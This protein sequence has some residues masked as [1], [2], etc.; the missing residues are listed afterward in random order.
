MK[1]IGI[2]LTTSAAEEAV[3][4]YI[5]KPL[6]NKFAENIVIND[7]ILDLISRNEKE[8]V[9]CLVTKEVKK[10]KKNKI[11]NIIF[12]CSS[13][14]H[15]KNIAVE[16][17]VRIFAIDDFLI[18]ETE[19]IR[20]IAFLATAPSALEN[21]HNLFNSFQIIENHLINKA[22]ECL[23]KGKKQKHNELIENYVYLM[24]KDIQ[25]I[26]LGQISM[27]GAFSNISKKI[28][29]PVVSGA[30]SLVKNLLLQKEPR[31]IILYDS[32]SYVTKANKDR[33][34]ISGS[35]GGIPSVKYAINK[36]VFGAVFNDAGVGKNNAGI[37][38]LSVLDNNG[39]LGIT[40]DRNSAEIGNAKDTYENG[41]ISYY[42]DTAKYYGVQ[43]NMRIKDFI[44]NLTR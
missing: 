5:C 23:L 20:K 19:S 36:K 40:V 43:K 6:K 29:T 39:I 18:K 1:K 44:E 34:I 11:F 12:T 33:F 38:G 3:A 8:K 30:T 21:S 10:F 27:M 41:L 7:D 26:V 13:I 15:L 14:S 35:H 4:E 9:K 17:G 2:L 25:C 32:I 22:F 24:P 42:N 16:E 31:G 28:N 37:L